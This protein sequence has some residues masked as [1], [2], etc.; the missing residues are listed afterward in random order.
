MRSKL[1]HKLR[2]TVKTEAA[3]RLEVL[4]DPR[5]LRALW[6]RYL[7]EAVDGQMRSTPFLH[8]LWYS[9]T[10]MAAVQSFQSSSLNLLATRARHSA[11]PGP[12]IGGASAKPD[13]SS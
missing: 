3:R 5:Q 9:L 8:W 1:G 11:R 12:A 2:E 4:G 6:L 13:A 10:A 7:S